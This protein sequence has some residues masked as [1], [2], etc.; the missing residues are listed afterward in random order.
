MADMTPAN[1][2]ADAAA[3]TVTSGSV[4]GEVTAAA[5][6]QA[7]LAAIP[8]T[9]AESVFNLIQTV[10]AAALKV[11]GDSAD[12]DLLRSYPAPTVTYSQ[13]DNE[14]S[15]TS[16]LRFKEAGQILDSVT[17]LSD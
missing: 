10:S 3:N 11:N 4:R 14:F 6:V 17:S 7:F 15:Y 1:V 13:A 8:N 12:A 2:Q 9:M 5:A 16:T